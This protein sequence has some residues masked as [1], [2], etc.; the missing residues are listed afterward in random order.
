[1]I[2][3]TT[4]TIHIVE[5]YDLEHLI[6]ETYGFKDFSVPASEECG[7]D[8]AIQGRADTPD[9]FDVERIAKREQDYMV[10][11]YVDDLSER[12]LFP[13]GEYLIEVSW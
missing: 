13:K 12:G 9:K 7:N 6:N 8:T 2:K 3:H 1:M 5:H 10:R 11:A 4:R